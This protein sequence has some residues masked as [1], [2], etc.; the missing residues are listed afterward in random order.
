MSENAK[1]RAADGQ[2][3]RANE[4]NSAMHATSTVPCK[5]KFGTYMRT[6]DKFRELNGQFKSTGT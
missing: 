2:N 5:K 1:K 3:A 4:Q 6:R